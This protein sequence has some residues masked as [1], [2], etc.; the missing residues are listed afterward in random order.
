MAFTINPTNGD[1]GGTP[2]PSRRP[3]LTP[4]SRTMW[5]C[6]VDFGTSQAGNAKIDV[7][8]VCVDDGG[9]GS[10]IGAYTWDTFT[11]TDAAAWRMAQAA[12]ALHQS[13]QF[14][15]EDKA[16]VDEILRRRPMVVELVEETWNGKTRVRPAGVAYQPHQGEIPDA[17]E[18]TVQAGEEWHEGGKAKRSGSSFATSPGM[19][20]DIPF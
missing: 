15:A 16:V 8:L 17:W 3:T 6:G 5:I 12:R 2:S 18:D 13:D 4:G 19:D 10:E 7:R 11:L 9:D 1:A 14:D 20:A